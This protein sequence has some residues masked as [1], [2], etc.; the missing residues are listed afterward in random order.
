METGGVVWEARGARHLFGTSHGVFDSI[1]S[2]DSLL[3]SFG[4][5]ERS[6]EMNAKAGL[7][8]VKVQGQKAV[9]DGKA[10]IAGIV[11]KATK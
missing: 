8:D 5:R 3:P 7:E 11:D 10:A 9:Q 6:L 1:G 4:G 2:A